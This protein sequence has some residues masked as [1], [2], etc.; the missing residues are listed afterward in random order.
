MRCLGSLFLLWLLSS[1]PL[2]VLAQN[3][4]NAAEIKPGDNLV[5]EGIP[6]IPA[7]LAGVTR[8]YLEASPVLFSSWHPARREMLIAKRAGNTFQVHALAAPGAA[9]KQLTAFPDPV[10][11]GS[12]QRKAG[13]YFVFS[14]AAGGNEVRQLYRY[15]LATG[16]ISAITTDSKKRF[17]AHLWSNSGERLV[18]SLISTGDTGGVKF[19]L[20][21][22]DPDDLKTDRVI[23]QLDGA[24]WG[25]LDWSP[26]DRKLVLGEAVSV[27]ESYH[28]L[29]DVETG[30]KT[31]L[32]PRGGA[33]KIAY[34]TARFSQDGKGLYTTT[35]RDAEFNR[36][37]YLDLATRRAA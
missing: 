31:L 1:F 36:L 12:F 15:E 17:A 37:L 32:T 23:A 7:E 33:E 3:A 24:G 9:P 21:L 18:Y 30:E 5:V 28:W 26:D 2:G 16:Q 27:N 8:K 25:V 4:G 29:L 13:A 11:S 22:V 6:R 35:D 14:R 19:E 10:M 20:H 34:G